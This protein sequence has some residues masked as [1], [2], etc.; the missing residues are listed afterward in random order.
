MAPRGFI[1]A[2]DSGAQ[3]HENIIRLIKSLSQLQSI[4][5]R[6]PVMTTMR[7]DER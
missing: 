2:A 6:A 3:Y 7:S 4:V 5:F 1:E